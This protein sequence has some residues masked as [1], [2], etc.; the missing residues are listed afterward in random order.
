MNEWGREE[1]MK[2][3]EKKVEREG[4]RREEKDGI[5]DFGASWC[6]FTCHLWRNVTLR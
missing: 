4:G 1:G 3:G 2:E 6:P 5:Y